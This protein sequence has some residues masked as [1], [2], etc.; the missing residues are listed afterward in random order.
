M[1]VKHILMVKFYPSN[2][3]HEQCVL[4]DVLYFILFNE[5]KEIARGKSGYT[6]CKIHL[7]P[8]L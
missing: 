6:F 2:V 1:Q 8:S 5:Y 4:L 3:L 7:T